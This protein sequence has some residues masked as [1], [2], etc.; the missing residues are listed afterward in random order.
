MPIIDL[1]LERL[2]EYKPPLTRR[3]DFF[4]FWDES[5][6]ISKEQ[7]LNTKVDEV[8]YPVKRLKVY[9]LLFD[10]FIDRSPINAWLLK[11]NEDGPLPAMIFF[12]GYGGNRGQVSDYLGWVLQGYVVMAVDVRGQ[13]GESPDFAKYPS[14]SLIGNM[15]KGILD[16]NSYY[17]RYVYMDCLRALEVLYGR[18]DVLSDKVGVTG[19]SQGGGLALVTSALDKRVALSLPEVPYLCHFERAIEVATEGPYLEVLGFM[20]THPEDVET[21][22]ETLSYFDAM[23]FAT[24]MNR[25]VLMSVGL[26]DTICPASTVFAAFNHIPSN[27]KELSIYHGMGHESLGVHHEKKIRWAAAHL[28]A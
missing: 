11:P 7:P 17:Y 3:N 6:K 8:A 13:S 20:K 2:K 19:V 4:L 9:R 18:E 22:K 14:G 1:P 27:D 26:I 12:H 16:K 10:G 23:N 24:E 15:T 25:S 21:V 5:L 28:L